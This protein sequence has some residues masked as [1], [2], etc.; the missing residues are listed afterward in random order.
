MNPISSFLIVKATKN[1]IRKILTKEHF[2]FNEDDVSALISGNEKGTR[3]GN[4]VLVRNEDGVHVERFIKI[5]LDGK[6]K[7]Y[8]P[9][10]RQT[11]LTESFSSNIPTNSRKS[12]RVITYSL[13]HPVP[14]AIFETRTTGV[15]FGFMHDTPEF[16]ASLSATDLRHIVS[17]MLMFH[18]KG[19]TLQPQ[20]RK[21]CV[22]TKNTRSFYRHQLSILLNQKIK[23][24]RKNGDIVTV[25]VSTLLNEYTTVHNVEKII[26]SKF[27]N[28]FQ[29]VTKITKSG[30]YLTHGDM[31][32][33]NIYKHKD[34]SFELLDFE[35]VGVCN[36]PVIPIMYDYG[37]LRARAWSHRAFQHQLDKETFTQLCD[38]YHNEKLAS[39]AVSLGKILFS[40]MMARFHLDYNNTVTKDRRTEE[41]Y[42]LMFPATLATLKEVLE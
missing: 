6:R 41:E 35:W 21:L 25:A 28:A 34:G 31:Q 13:K 40:V 38:V 4:K 2:I 18:S 32:I 14:Y 3:Y 12:L 30:T 22:Q 10:R 7:T 11:L 33:D 19:Q 37:N 8:L 24:K 15:N 23:H 27:S 26:F 9:F 42:F 39:D 5:Q 1:H 17:E 29:S 20:V 16:Y 36:N